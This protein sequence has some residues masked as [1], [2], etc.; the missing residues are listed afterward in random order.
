VVTSLTMRPWRDLDGLGFCGFL[1]YVL[2]AKPH[3]LKRR[4]MRLCGCA[5]RRL[6][7]NVKRAWTS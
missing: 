4:R 2:R 3:V 6:S 7:S 1:A 5:S